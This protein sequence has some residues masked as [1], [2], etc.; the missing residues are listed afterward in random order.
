MPPKSHLD[1]ITSSGEVFTATGV[2]ARM[3]LW[4]CQNADHVSSHPT[5]RL[6]FHFGGDSCVPEL[7]HVWD[8][9]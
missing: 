9:S 3:V 6:L 2:V 4:L 5:G 7:T 1:V 8:R